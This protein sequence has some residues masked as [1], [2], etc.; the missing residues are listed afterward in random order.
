M[1]KIKEIIKENESEFDE[2]ALLTDFIECYSNQDFDELDDYISEFA[3]N[4][5][6][7]YNSYIIDEWKEKNCDGLTL[8]ELGE[9]SGKTIIE[10]MSSDL[11]FYYQNKLAS[12]FEK[13]KE[14]IK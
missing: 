14:I 13:L 5:V 11:Y 3:D 4:Q 2:I 10:N 9:Y 6:P 12:D 7:V 1:D 8:D